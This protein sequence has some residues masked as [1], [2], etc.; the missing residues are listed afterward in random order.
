[1]FLNPFH[2]VSA[3][4]VHISPEQASRFAKEVAG[5]F[6][7]IHDPGAKRYCVPGDLLFSLVL[8]HYGLS[9]RMCFSFSGMVGEDALLH[10]P[11]SKERKLAITDD[12]QRTC[13]EVERDGETSRNPALI[14]SFTRQYVAFSG[15][16]FPHVLLPL[17]QSQG[18]MIN[19]DRPLVIYESMSIQLDHLNFSGPVLEDADHELRVNGKR[20]D[21]RLMFTIHGQ[22]G[23]V[24]RG[25]KKLVVSG[26]KPYQ[27]SAAQQVVAD[28]LANKRDYQ[29]ANGV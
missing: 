27:E 19:P 1:M 24:G 26:L 10:F 25:F 17:L 3:R 20:G 5:D 15:R 22:D 12:R 11:D 29:Q 18:V 14:E 16:N 23:P 28:Y 7:P 9:Q 2:Q 13:L 6:N 4:G 21:V 8:N